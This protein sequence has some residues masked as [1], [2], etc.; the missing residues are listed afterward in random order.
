MSENPS[1]YHADL[2]LAPDAGLE[3]LAREAK[4][5]GA[6]FE[7]EGLGGSLVLPVMADLRRGW[8]GGPV[9][10]R[11]EDGGTRLTLQVEESE[12]HL[13]RLSVS[14]LLIAAFGSLLF[15]VAPWV[16]ALRPA[17]PLGIMLAVGAWF[18]I[19]ARLRNSGP[20]DF[21]AELEAEAAET[22]EPPSPQS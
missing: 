17:I 1:E 14:V 15:V 12:Y 21:F 9:T 2:P 7:R 18:F 19:V 5:W 3:L 6:G 20:E 8:V 22:E 4:S 10:A 11:E 13:E 16:P